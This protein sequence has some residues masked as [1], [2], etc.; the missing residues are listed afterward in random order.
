MSISTCIACADQLKKVPFFA[1]LEND[2][3]EMLT[4]LFRWETFHPGSVICREGEPGDC[5]YII[6]SGSVQVFSQARQLGGHDSGKTNANSSVARKKSESAIAKGILSKQGCHFKTWKQRYCVLRGVSLEYYECEGVQCVPEAVQRGV[7]NTKTLS[8]F[9]T[10]T[11]ENSTEIGGPENGNTEHAGTGG[12]NR[13]LARLRSTSDNS[14]TT[15]ASSTTPECTEAPTKAYKSTLISLSKEQRREQCMSLIGNLRPSGK[16]ILKGCFEVVAAGSWKGEDNGFVVETKGGRLVAFQSRSNTERDAWLKAIVAA[17][18]INRSRS[19]DFTQVYEERKKGKVL[20][21]QHKLN[22]QCSLRMLKMNEENPNT[23]E[24]K[25]GIQWWRMSKVPGLGKFL[26]KWVIEEKKDRGSVGSEGDSDDEEER[27]YLVR[28]LQ[29]GSYFGE[30]GLVTNQPRNATVVAKEQTGVIKLSDSNFQTFINVVPHL[31]D[32]INNMVIERSAA[33]LRA[34]KVPFLEGF[35]EEKFEKLAQ[36]GRLVRLKP[37]EIV[38]RQGDVGNTFYIVLQ[39]LVDVRQIKVGQESTAGSDGSLEEKNYGQRINTLKAGSYFVSTCIMR[40]GLELN[41]YLHTVCNQLSHLQGEIAL[42]T[43]GERMAT[44]IAIENTSLLELGREHFQALFV[45]EA[46]DVN[47]RSRRLSVVSAR[48]TTQSKRRA[49]SKRKRTTG[50]RTSVEVSNEKDFTDDLLDDVHNFSEFELKLFHKNCEMEQVLRHSRGIQYFR[51]ALQKEHSEE[52][53]NFWE[54]TRAHRMKYLPLLD[55]LPLNMKKILLAEL[56]RNTSHEVA[57]LVMERFKTNLER[58]NS[59]SAY[60]YDVLHVRTLESDDEA[61]DTENVA[62]R[63]EVIG[64]SEL[65]AKVNEC[66]MSAL[67]I[68]TKYVV[69]TSRQQVNIPSEIRSSLDSCIKVIRQFRKCYKMLEADNDTFSEFIEQFNCGEEN[70]H[71]FNQAF[72]NLSRLFVEFAS[73]YNES[74]KEI[75]DLMNRDNFRRFKDSVLFDDLMK[76]IQSYNTGST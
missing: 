72:L 45:K 35:T 67:E 48:R 27:Q 52:N 31:R 9:A 49:L 5:M 65:F 8:G 53:L 76:E 11:Y 60:L 13:S 75:R 7:L 20:A 47:Q 15:N 26:N 57:I 19:G 30:I 17:L 6:M 38:F 3:I 24:D 10:S 46:G 39:G 2:K 37:K 4:N 33:N 32:E 34:L 22:H 64:L 12:S 74:Q 36:L 42:L 73:C 68:H 44:I 23:E 1:T 59:P 41:G 16:R 40:R 62:E 58:C 69:D 50:S 14:S 63:D 18:R 66:C 43:Q 55:K 51:E 29:A 56:E 21:K 28:D 61:S 54:A 70:Y 71:T 25:K